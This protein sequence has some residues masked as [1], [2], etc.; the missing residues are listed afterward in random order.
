VDTSDSGIYPW[1][2]TS[3]SRIY[4]RVYHAPSSQCFGTCIVYMMYLLLKF[5]S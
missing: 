1:V 3:D 2:D 5:S 4:P